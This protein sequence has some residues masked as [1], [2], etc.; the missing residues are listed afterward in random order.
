MSHHDHGT[1]QSTSGKA[2]EKHKPSTPKSASTKTKLSVEDLVT[3]LDDQNELIQQLLTEAKETKATIATLRLETEE[4]KKT[5]TSSLIN[6]GA[7]PGE[8]ADCKESI[9]TLQVRADKLEADSS[10]LEEY[11]EEL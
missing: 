1:R 7:L 9:E 11:K 4:Y 3:K 5:I 6:Y 2:N 10:H 8:V